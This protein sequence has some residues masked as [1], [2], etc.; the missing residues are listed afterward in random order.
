MSNIVEKELRRVYRAEESLRRQAYKDDLKW[1]AEIESKIPE[2][3]YESLRNVFR[4]TFEIIFEKGTGIIEKT[5]NKEDIMKD[6][7]VRDFSVDLDVSS[8][9]YLLL[10][11]RSDLSNLVSLLAS[12]VEGVGLGALGIGMPDIVLFTSVI[13]R[14]CYETA[15]R[16]GFTYDTASEKYFI[17]TLLE[18]SLLKKQDWDTCNKRVDSLLVSLYTPSEQELKT[19]IQ[20]TADAFAIDMLVAKF[21]QG[22]PVV[23]VVGGLT[24]PLYYRK[25]QRYIRLKY[26]KRYLLTKGNV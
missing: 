16:Y 9:D 19:Q 26:K 20:H 8:K 17:L 23:G 12:T 5:Y 24:N 7:L 14:G 15:L 10:N 1:K 3:V 18:G 2:K 6:F 21:I 4:K 11:A 13:L 25:I 22:I